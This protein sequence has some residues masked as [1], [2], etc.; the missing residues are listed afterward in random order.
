LSDLSLYPIGAGRNGD[1]FFETKY[2][3]L[4]FF[5]LNTQMIVELGGD[6]EAC[7]KIIIYKKNGG[8]NH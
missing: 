3:E 4:V 1:I 7:L 5:D 6:E 2:G 8:I